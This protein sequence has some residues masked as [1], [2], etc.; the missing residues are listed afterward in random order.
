MIGPSMDSGSTKILAVVIVAIIAIAGVAAF[1]MLSG[2]GGDKEDT[3][4]QKDITG[5]LEVFGNANNDD[6]I[7]DNDLK[8][9]DSFIKNNAWDKNKYPFADANG[10]GK[11]T[12]DDRSMVE[13]MISKESVDV[14]YINGNGDVKT[15]HFPV[16]G[17]VVGG[18][19]VHPVINAVGAYDKA[20]ALT[21]KAS[22]VDPVLNAPT[23]KLPSV[24]SKAY[25][26]D[27]D[28]LSKY[29]ANAVFTL[30]T[31]VYDGIED[32]L[33]NIPGISCIRINPDDSDKSTQTFLLVGFLTG[34]SD[35][36]DKIVA[37]YDKYNKVIADNVVKIGT[38]KTTLTMYTSSMCGT[39]YYLTKN[40]VAAGARNLSDFNDANTKKIKDNPEWAADEKYQ[41]E[42]I[43]EF[44]GFDM[45]W[46][47]TL[48]ELQEEFEYYGQYF[49]LMKA[50]PEKYVVI[51]KDMPD[52]ARTAYVAQVL[53]PGVFGSAFGDNLYKELVKTFYPYIDSF[54]PAK[55]TTVVVDY[56]TAYGVMPKVYDNTVSA[57]V[58]V[59]GNA[60]ND[61]YI[62]SDDVKIIQAIAD[63]KT[64]WD[65]EKIPYA[66]ANCDGKVDSADVTLVNN[67][68][69]KTKS[70][71]Y[72]KNYF[73]ENQALNFPLKNRKICVTYW[74]Q[75][76]EMAILG[77][78]QNV[79]V[80]SANVTERNGL[81]YDLSN[82]KT[83][84][85]V[86][87]S[88]ITDAGAEVIT[89]EGIDLIVATPSST[90]K[91]TADKFI[92]KGVDVVYLWYAAEY[93]IPTIMTM[94]ILM[95]KETKAKEYY[96]YCSSVESKIVDKV[97]GNKANVLVTC[98][99]EDEAS[100]YSSKGGMDVLS[101]DQA[102]AYYLINKIGNAYHADDTDNWGYSYRSTEWIIANDTFDWII[103]CESGA[104][105]ANVDGHF[106]TQ[107]AY[108]ERFEK[109]VIY[110]KGTNAYKSGNLIG[111]TFDFLSGFSGYAMLP[112]I[113]SQMYGDSVYSMEEA[114]G[115]LQ[116][117]F[118]NFTAADVDVKSQGGYRYTGTEYKTSY[119][120]SP[121]VSGKGFYKWNP[122][123]VEVDGNYSN[124][125]PAF[126][127]IAEGVFAGVYG[128]VPGYSG[129]TR[130]SIPSEYLY[131]YNSYVTE[132]SDGTLT[133]KTF[134]NTSLGTSEAFAD[135]KVK[136]VPT[137]ILCYTDAYVDTI[138]MI[139]C[140]YYGETAH[141]GNTP[142]AT[143]K[144]W[145]LVTAM[146]SSVASGL[147]T[148]YGLT[149]P[150]SV[151]IIGGSQ[152]DL[153]N[154]CGKISGEDK[155]IVFM[156][157]YNIRATN[158][159]SWWGTNTSIESKA[160]NIQFIYL[161]SNSPAMVLST[162]EM[163]GKVIGFDNTDAMMTS[164]LAKI[165]VMQKAIDESG[166]KK[167]F[168]V[169]MAN[170]NAVGSNTLMGGIFA[171]VLKMD[172]VFDGSLMGNKM[173][174]ENIVLS[175]PQV[176]GFYKADTRSMDEKMRAA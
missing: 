165:Y 123:V 36:A 18:T 96:D 132:N 75:A 46:K 148:K 12:S 85:T 156:S 135:K 161:L 22:N 137:K 71:V 38:K 42:Y 140:D 69:S 76:E 151:E 101:G 95:D 143:A 124:C 58:P 110:Y 112:V 29:K 57:T 81:L 121:S 10:D 68:I 98:L 88:K 86:G 142:K 115:N 8:A 83:I 9:I 138:Y 157:E 53:Y 82:V 21:G 17:L 106:F 172:N 97:G 136:F 119:D 168:Y 158:K 24:G 43:I 63:G 39:D 109:N 171:S 31:S 91:E 11:I 100:R 47:P 113:A 131:P 104:G 127:D 35:R 80:A 44:S 23:S 141:S 54:D 50:Y 48:S 37:F 74:Q 55:D 163:I 159:S 129:I 41:A 147:Q 139:I 33:K 130:E 108:N 28:E 90:V 32:A 70:T 145:E 5:R 72:Y 3:S 94:G 93:T 105:F 122:V 160:D 117:W 87:S 128:E 13:K 64:A 27:I 1:L 6:H 49:T 162:M 16:T 174:D 19:A 164:V 62:N 26:I 67:I 118:D 73:G 20:V 155:L 60:N 40:T 89:N 56:N 146:P 169:E 7:D 25:S 66:D 79:R 173:S 14:R 78:W 102:G 4:W 126:M 51:N 134:D 133:V 34:H 125:T 65:K 2:N 144:L 152:E 150:E 120:N 107:D 166:G 84:G 92:A 45:I 99:F 111:S 176:I 15:A 153:L 170:G 61:L 116:Y 59:Y 154:Y 30:N 175:Q 114:L 77:E 103:D 52:I 167:T 149:A